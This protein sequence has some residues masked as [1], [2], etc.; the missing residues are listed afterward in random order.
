[1]AETA[2]L[3]IEGLGEPGGFLAGCTN[4]PELLQP[5][6]HQVDSTQASVLVPDL[7]EVSNRQ[8][9]TKLFASA[10]AF[11]VVY[12]I[13]ASVEDRP[14]GVDLDCQCCEGMS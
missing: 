10:D 7:Q 13:P 6:R 14:A 11:V 12:E 1:M 9:R 5:E 8:V 4:Q 2:A 3:A